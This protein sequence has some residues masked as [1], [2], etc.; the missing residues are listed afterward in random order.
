MI[1]TGAVILGE[2]PNRLGVLGILITCIGG[3]V[4]NLDMGR[5]NFKDPF[6]AIIREKGSW[7]ML[8][9]AFIFSFAAVVGKKGILHS[10]PLFFTISF[11]V[12]FN[13]TIIFGLLAVG[14]IQIKTYTV[15]PGKGIIAGT[16]LFLH[17]V[18]HG[19][20]ISLTKA[21]Y[22]ISIKR[23]S[24][25]FGVIFGAVFFQERN[26]GIRLAGATLMLS[27]AALIILRG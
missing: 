14:K 13:L 16:L 5:F 21:A 23:L 26:I 3:Y 7:L 22:M 18:S 20:A 9:V 19:F 8:I 2:V 15:A 6:L 1:I 4:L 11:F 10:S 24:I 12:A 17:A 25:L 27:G